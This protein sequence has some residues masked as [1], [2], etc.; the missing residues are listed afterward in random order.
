[1]QAK[2]MFRFS[3]TVLLALCSGSLFAAEIRV[4]VASN[5]SKAMKAIA[6]QF[7]TITEHQVKLSFGSTGKHYA[8]IIN[9]APFDAFFAADTHRPELLEKNGH[10]LAGSRFTY[11]VGKIVL[12]S[13]Q[14]GYVDSQGNVLKQGQFRYLSMANPKLAPYG[15]AAQEILQ[16]QGLWDELSVQFVRGENI[17]QAYQFVKSGNADLGFVAWSQLV[18]A[19]HVVE[20][21]YWTPP[22]SLYTP[23]EQQAVKLTDNEAVDALMSFIRSREGIE[24]I[25]EY[26]YDT[27]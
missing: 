23:I 4:A 26:G 3:I 2:K 6:G 20:G 7:E 22:Q 13:P 19:D 27:R 11:A 1:M 15:M 17:A 9:G 8:Q 21:S 10:A 12:W 16:T 5:F 24:I 25:H 18:N 14:P